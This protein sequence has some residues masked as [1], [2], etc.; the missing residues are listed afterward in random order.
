[1]NIH[2]Y[3]EK[4]ASFRRIP[5]R[6]PNPSNFS[7]TSGRRRIYYDAKLP[8]TGQQAMP[9]KSAPGSM[10]LDLERSRRAFQR[11]MAAMDAE[12]AALKARTEAAAARAASRTTPKPKKKGFMGY[13]KALLGP[14][15]A[16]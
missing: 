12:N 9:P 15:F 8:S 16:G 2:E 1:M 10:E 6:K 7:P 4:R 11:R 13:L 14:G 3:L 5:R